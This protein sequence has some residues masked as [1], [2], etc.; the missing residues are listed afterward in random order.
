MTAEQRTARLQKLREAGW[1]EEKV[2][3]YVQA[4]TGRTYSL[5]EE[6]R[7]DTLLDWIDTQCERIPVREAR[8]SKLFD[9]W[10]TYCREAGEGAPGSLADFIG[11]LEEVGAGERASGS[12]FRGL[13][14]KDD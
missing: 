10:Q 1:S 7:R 8:V 3:A 14:L 5:E 9:S 2:K 4:L 6:R 11:W 13:K 12:R